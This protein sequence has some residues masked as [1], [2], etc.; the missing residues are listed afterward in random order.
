[1]ESDD[2]IPRIPRKRSLSPSVVGPE[3]TSTRPRA[4]KRLRRTKDIPEY[5][6]PILAA[7]LA[8]SNPM[9]RKV[10]KK[11][12]KKVRRANRGA[13]A[14]GSG[15]MEVDG[16]EHGGLEFTFMATTEGVSF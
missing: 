4:P 13:V 2:L 11:E 5:D 8:K 16:M 6:A 15:G 14:A 3:P 12:A 10:L 7:S 9:N 1:M